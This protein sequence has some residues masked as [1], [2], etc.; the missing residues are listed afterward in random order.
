MTSTLVLLRH[1]KSAY[2]DGVADHDRPLSPR[3]LR[4]A[5]VAGE[6]LAR[7]LPSIEIALVSTATRTQ[8]TW[9]LARSALTVAQQENV[10][11]LYLASA[12]AMLGRIRALDTQSALVVSHNP[13]TE[14]LA[15]QLTQNTDSSAYLHMLTKFPTAAF[16]VL[17][18]DVPFAQWGYGV[19]Q[20]LAFEVGRG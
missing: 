3:G 14:V 19:A 1:A 4:D 9:D 2:P 15:E 6:L 17:Q 10:P 13:G 16:A 8:Q 5:P 20:L 18:A 12:D 7:H 11:E